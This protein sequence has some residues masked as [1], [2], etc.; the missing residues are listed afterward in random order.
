[1]VR[2]PIE[3]LLERVEHRLDALARGADEVRQR[4]LATRSR[5][6]LL[7]RRV[8]CRLQAD[9]Y[10]LARAKGLAGVPLYLGHLQERKRQTE[11]R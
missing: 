2:R 5:Q 1:M 10:T 9:H 3:R 6:R 8:A 11:A 4:R 7:D